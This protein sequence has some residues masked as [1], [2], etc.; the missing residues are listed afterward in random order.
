MSGSSMLEDFTIERGKW[1][2]LWGAGFRRE[3]GG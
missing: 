3:R 1:S 2:I